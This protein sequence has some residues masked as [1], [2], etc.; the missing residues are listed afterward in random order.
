[1]KRYFAVL[2]T[3]LMI[4]IVPPVNAVG[5]NIILN[6]DFVA[7]VSGWTARNGAEITW[8][9]EGAQGSTGCAK[10]KLVGNLSAISQENLHL[11]PGETYQIS[12]Y[13]RTES[14]NSTASLI[15]HFSGKKMHSRL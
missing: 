4:L 3:I 1:M 2:M 14:G 10:I 11:I 12:F 9:S 6:H 7:D 5:E 13:I 8:E 15:W